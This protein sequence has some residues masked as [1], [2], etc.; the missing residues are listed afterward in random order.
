MTD[1]DDSAY[2]MIVNHQ[3]LLDIFSSSASS[4]ISSGIEDE[5]SRP[6]HRLEHAP[7]P[8]RASPRRS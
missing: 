3:S 4:V 2:V 1:R 5:N 6:V 8:H 7:Q